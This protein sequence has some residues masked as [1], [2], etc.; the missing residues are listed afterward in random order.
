VRCVNGHE[1][2]VEWEN[3]DCCFNVSDYYNTSN[4]YPTMAFFEGQPME[5]VG[6]IREPATTE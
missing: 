1:G 5:V 4:D 6:N 3:H 2:I